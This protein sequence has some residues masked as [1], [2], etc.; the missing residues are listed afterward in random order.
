MADRSHIYAGVAGYVGRA[1]EKG[2]VGV[3]RRAAAGGEWQHVLADLETHALLVHPTDL[4]VVFAGTADGVWRSTD[5]GATFQ[6]AS[7]PDKGK[8]IWSFLVDSRDAKRIYAGASPVDSYRSDDQGGSWRRLPNPGIKDRATA[9]FAVR[10]MRMAQHPKRPE[11]IYAA[12]EVNGVIAAF[13][14]SANVVRQRLRLASVSPRLL[15]VYAEDG[16]SLDQ[17][18]AFTVNPD[19]ARQA[20]VWEALQRTPIREPYQIRRLLTASAVR[21]SDKRA[22][23]VGVADYEAAGGI[24]LRDL[25]ES[26]DGGW[27]QDPAL[28]ERLVAGKLEREAGAVRAEGWNWVEAAPEF[29]YGHTY[30]LRRLCGTE[31]AIT[32][33]E[34]AARDALKAELDKLEESYAEA[35]DIPEDVDQRLGEIETALATFEQR[36]LL[37]DAAEVARAGAFVSIDASGA[38]RIERGC[39]RPGDEA[40][41]LPVAN[42]GYALPPERYNLAPGFAGGFFPAGNAQ[43][44]G[45]HGRAPRPRASGEARTR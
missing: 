28:L 2:K 31:V 41:V 4:N 22:Q 14:V 6:R 44:F 19:H 21:A 37:Y 33:D 38:L 23:F 24:V 15:D 43:A 16:M 39:V 1:G 10:V 25:F 32:E 26:D 8:Q 36:P 42:K 45:A 9:P 12:L 40:P 13:F 27:L 30:G 11:E 3:F 35:E 29:P 7:F 5:R 18:M 17:L 20:E 34:A